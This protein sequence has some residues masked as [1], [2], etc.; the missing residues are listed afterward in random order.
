MEQFYEQTLEQYD[1]RLSDLTLLTSQYLERKIKDKQIKDH[2]CK[3]LSELFR[4]IDMLS[5]FAQINE[6]A[7][8][9]LLKKHDK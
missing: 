6:Q 9:K 4:L 3:N 7:I 2:I 5:N 1:V 8:S